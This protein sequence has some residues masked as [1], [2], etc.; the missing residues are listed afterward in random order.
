MKY[1]RGNLPSPAVAIIILL[2]LISAVPKAM[3][4]DVPESPLSDTNTEISPTQIFKITVRDDLTTPGVN[5]DLAPGQPSELIYLSKAGAIRVSCTP[6]GRKSAFGPSYS[7]VVSSESGETIG[8]M[9][10]G[11]NTTATFTNL[12]V[13]IYMLSFDGKNVPAA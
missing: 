11:S 8:Q 1:F 10:I 7:L 2:A 6:T 12:G 9:N 4:S 13:Q 5:L 3:A